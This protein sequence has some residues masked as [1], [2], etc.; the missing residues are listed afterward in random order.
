M[1]FS[2]CMKFVIFST[3]K[4]IAKR[5]VEKNMWILLCTEESFQY[6]KC[7]S[8]SLTSIEFLHVDEKPP[9][10][11]STSV[12]LCSSQWK[13]SFIPSCSPIRPLTTP[14]TSSLDEKKIISNIYRKESL[15]RGLKISDMIRCSSWQRQSG[16]VLDTNSKYKLRA[17]RFPHLIALLHNNLVVRNS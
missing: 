10:V 17:I 13:R 2:N 4:T 15:P 8:P 6:D 16:A 11:T 5:S 14:E 3:I 9:S 7:L 1:Q 12:V